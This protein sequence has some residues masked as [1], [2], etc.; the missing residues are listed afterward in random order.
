MCFHRCFVLQPQ[1]LKSGL[2]GFEILAV[3]FCDVKQEMAACLLWSLTHKQQQRCSCWTPVWKPCSILNFP[4]VFPSQ[5]C[6]GW[7][8][9]LIES[10][11]YWLFLLLL[12]PRLRALLLT[13]V[14]S[15]APAVADS[16][17]GEA[18]TTKLG[19]PLVSVHEF[20]RHVWLIP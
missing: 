18:F 5:L 6:H 8:F 7:A 17:P 10:R 9:N 15:C 4:G 2:F 13:R 12:L 20:E 3:S 11:T 16:P 14:P 1:K 19:W